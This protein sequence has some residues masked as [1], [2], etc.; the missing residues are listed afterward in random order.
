MNRF[1]GDFASRFWFTYR[2]DFT[3]IDDTHLTSDIGWGCMLRSSQMMMGHAFICHFMG[4]GMF[5]S[6]EEVCSKIL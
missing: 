4:R 5:R 6:W 2:K 3:P 1:K